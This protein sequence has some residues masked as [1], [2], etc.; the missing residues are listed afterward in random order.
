M[1]TD[2][3]TTT[4]DRTGFFLEMIAQLSSSLEDVIGLEDAEGYFALVGTSIGSQ[5]S[6]HYRK[7]NGHDDLTAQQIAE[8]LV[9][10]KTRIDGGFSIESVTDTQITLVN[11]RC[12][13]GEKVIGRRSL[14]MM[15]SNVFGTIAADAAG[16]ATVDLQ[17]TIAAGDAGC[18]VVVH[19]RR[20]DT[21]GMAYFGAGA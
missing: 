7:A 8:A 2:D 5:M 12:P 4:F 3:I 19:L 21:P 6:A 14:C 20:S 9:D 1:M 13:F 11:T 15:T 16:R 10:L 17:E 18:R